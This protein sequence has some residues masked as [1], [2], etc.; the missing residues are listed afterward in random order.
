MKNSNPSDLCEELVKR[1]TD[2]ISGPSFLSILQNM[3][4]IPATKDG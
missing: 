4:L 2:S 1:M 3:F